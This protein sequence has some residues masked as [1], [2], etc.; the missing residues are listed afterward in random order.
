[1]S[2][3]HKNELQFLIGCTNASDGK[4][5]FLKEKVLGRRR[6]KGKQDD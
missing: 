3:N 4:I 1:L 5:D 2:D 6:R